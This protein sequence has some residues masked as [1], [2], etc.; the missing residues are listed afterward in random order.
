MILFHFLKCEGLEGVQRLWQWR[1]END[2]SVSPCKEGRHLGAMELGGV[3][4]GVR[5]I[6]KHQLGGEEMFSCSMIA[7]GT[8]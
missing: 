8:D 6:R 2:R 7:S 5:A 4:L 1:C 3:C